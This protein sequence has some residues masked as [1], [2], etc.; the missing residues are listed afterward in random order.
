MM[1]RTYKMISVVT[2]E[3]RFFNLTPCWVEQLLRR[4]LLS[5]RQDVQR[6][7]AV[8]IRFVHTQTYAIELRSVLSVASDAIHLCDFNWHGYLASVCSEAPLAAVLA[9]A[10]VL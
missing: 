9:P 2:F 7:F 3:E 6:C 10:S 8:G 5:V 1:K 4:T